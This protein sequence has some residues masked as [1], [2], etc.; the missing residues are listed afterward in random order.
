M[1]KFN[2]NIRVMIFL[3]LFIM[4][5]FIPVDSTSAKSAGDQQ[6]SVNNASTLSI[7]LSTDTVSMEVTPG[8]FASKSMTVTVSTNNFSGYELQLSDTDEDNNLTNDTDYKIPVVPDETAEKDFSPS[9]WGYLVK[10]SGTGVYNGV[11]VLS[12]PASIKLT[13]EAASS[14]ETT[15]TF[16][17]DISTDIASGTYTDSVIFTA[18][19]NYIA[20]TRT[21][22]DID[23]MQ[24]MSYD[25]CANTTTPLTSATKYDT[26][27]SHAGDA[28]Y[29]PETTLIDNRDGKEYTIRKLSGGS[30][31]M[32]ENLRL[33]LDNYGDGTFA[34]VSDSGEKTQLTSEN[35]N[36]KTSTWD[37]SKNTN[38]TSDAY[39][40]TT[41]TSET[42]S[43]WMSDGNDEANTLNVP[44][45]YTNGDLTTT[46]YDGDTQYYGNYYNWYAATAGTGTA[47]RVFD[48]YDAASSICPAGWQL[49]KFRGDKSYYRLLRIRYGIEDSEAGSILARS[50][51]LSFIYSGIYTPSGTITNQDDGGRWWEPR[52]TTDATTA[53][54]LNITAS[55]VRPQ[56]NTTKNSGQ[57]IRC[58]SKTK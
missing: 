53:H 35:T 9:A 57:S 45:S 22:W 49:P 52:A 16:G 55:H 27:G 39:N 21:I 10:D 29:V 40:Y 14:D 34:A 56:N 46:T 7:S 41:M 38:I 19:A 50:K 58:V 11:P 42:M 51:P 28:D 36:L 31:W 37:E 33:N 13:E 12:N 8:T 44:H 4:L 23:Y 1:S 54:R 2:K 32:V 30:C 24:E 43:S 15:I 18:V 17:V 25:I 3:A 20:D 6:F 5:L 48:N 47:D 26:D